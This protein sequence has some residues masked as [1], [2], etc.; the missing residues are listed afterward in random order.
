MAF[1]QAVDPARMDSGLD[2][3]G[4]LDWIEFHGIND[5]EARLQM[6]YGVGLDYNLD[7]K[8]QRSA[9]H[10]ISMMG[11]SNLAQ[12]QKQRIELRTMVLDFY[13]YYD[14]SKL[15]HIEGYVEWIETNGLPAFEQLLWQKYGVG[16]SGYAAES[17]QRGG[18]QQGVPSSGAVRTLAQKEQHQQEYNQWQEEQYYQKQ[19]AQEQYKQ[20]QIAHAQPSSPAQ[21][22]KEVSVSIL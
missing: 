13:T 4:M 2:V 5:M 6:N 7:K 3:N 21:P 17:S 10:R 19:W 9:M 15:E 1:Y 11:Y 20:E 22:V 16:L 8:P 12:Q 18:T 14:P